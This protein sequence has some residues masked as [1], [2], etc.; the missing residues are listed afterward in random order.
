MIKVKEILSELERATDVAERVGKTI[1][2]IIKTMGSGIT[3]ITPMEGFASQTASALTLFF[4][5]FFKVPVSTT[6]VITGSIMG[7]GAI[8]RLSAV[9]WGVTQKLVVAWLLTIPVSATL[10]A[11][12]Y[13][14]VGTWLY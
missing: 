11:V 12:I 14:V 7:A 8:K 4:V 1:K 13:Y 2:K 6:H 3:K 9:R 10:A 5:E